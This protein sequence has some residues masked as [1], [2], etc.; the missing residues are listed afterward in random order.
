MSLFVVPWINSEGCGL[1]P[2]ISKVAFWCAAAPP[3]R[4]QSL[5]GVTRYRLR[6]LPSRNTCHGD[7]SQ[8]QYTR[9]DSTCDGTLRFDEPEDCLLQYNKAAVKYKLN[10]WFGTK[11]E[12]NMSSAYVGEGGDGGAGAMAVVLVPKLHVLIYSRP[13]SFVPA[14]LGLFV[15]LGRTIHRG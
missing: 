7:N 15:L 13:N 12:S 4:P 5:I 6:R 9:G 8:A 11:S 2:S 3:L 1:P 14:P 10:T